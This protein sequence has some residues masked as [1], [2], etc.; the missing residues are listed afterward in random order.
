MEAAVG[1]QVADEVVLARAGDD[2]LGDGAQ[3]L[4]LLGRGDLRDPADGRH[5]DHRAQFGE[6][7]Q[8]ALADLGDPEALVAD[9]LDQSFP[10]QVEHGLTD[11][12]GRDAEFG[13]EA[14]CG[15]DAAGAQLTRY[16]RGPQCVADLVAE[17]L[18]G[19]DETV[20]LQVTHCFSSETPDTT[21]EEGNSVQCHVALLTP[22]RPRTARPP[23]RDLPRPC[24]RS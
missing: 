21:D 4:Q 24:P 5:L 10:G 1:L 2:L 15:V 23:R 22:R 6:L 3:R 19:L 12:G 9:G 8:V 20:L 16:Q 7:V 18:L 14:R 17:T 11:G 13:R